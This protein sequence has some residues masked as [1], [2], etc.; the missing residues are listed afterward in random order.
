MLV[1][2][3]NNGTAATTANESDDET[4]DDP[5]ENNNFRQV[6][7]KHAF[8]RHILVIDLFP[9]K[10][11][12]IN[13]IV[14]FNK[15]LKTRIRKILLEQLER[16]HGLKCW[17]N[18]EV[19]YKSIV[20]LDEPAFKR[21]LQT[22]YNMLTNEFEVADSIKQLMNKL[23]LANANFCREE[24]GL[25]LTRVIKA[26]VKIVQYQLLAGAHFVELP[27]FL[28][29]KNAIVNVKNEDNKCFAYAVLVALKADSLRQQRNLFRPARWTEFSMSTT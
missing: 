1:F 7:D 11:I 28:T 9:S 18:L 2:K 24:S 3:A 29:A 20:H 6:L 13:D 12:R 4:A 23:V 22:E 15:K 16:L 8:E 26:R 17:L 25:V 14:Q 10:D 19:E 27:Y 5:L 21:G